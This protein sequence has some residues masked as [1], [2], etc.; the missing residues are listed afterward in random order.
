MMDVSAS[1]MEAFDAEPVVLGGFVLFDIS[2]RFEGGEQA[3]DVVLVQFESF[4][5]FGY[6][7]FI[8]LAEELLEDVERVRDRLYNVVGFVAADHW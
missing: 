3:K 2:A 7:K 6:A 5:K 8:D 1:E 4:G